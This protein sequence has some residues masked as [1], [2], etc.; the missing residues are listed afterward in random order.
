MQTIAR[1]RPELSCSAMPR[2]R[3]DGNESTNVGQNIPYKAASSAILLSMLLSGCALVGPDFLKPSAPVADSYVPVESSAGAQSKSSAKQPAKVVSAQENSIQAEEL[4][5]WWTAFKDPTLNRL[6][7]MA[8]GQNLT[9]QSAGARVLEA[10]AALGIATGNLFPQEQRLGGGVDYNRLSKEDAFAI[11]NPPSNFWRA[12][13]GAQLAWELDFWGK[14]RRNIESADAAYIASV[15]NY[16]D[17]LVTLLA[18]VASTYIGIR[19]V[20]KQ[21]DL[22]NANIVRQQ[23]ALNIASD[24]FKNG[25]TSQ[26]D[27]FQAQNVLGATKARVPQLRIQL[28]EGID[29]LRVLLGIAPQSLDG[30]IANSAGIPAAPKAVNIGIPADLLR[31]RP[32]IRN[33]EFNAAAQSAQIGVAKAD[34]FPAFSLVGNVGFISSNVGRASLSDLFTH[35]AIAYSFGPTFQWNI[36]NYGQITNNVRVQDARL[37][38][39]LVDYQNS[40]LKAQQ[41]VQ[42]GI[43][44]FV[45]SDE[46]A[47]N[48]RDSVTAATGALNLAFTQY[49][50]GLTDFTTVLTAEQNLLDAENNLAI[51]TGATSTGLV[52]IYRALGG[53]WE[54]SAG[55]EFVPPATREEMKKRTNWGDLLP[56]SA[57]PNPET[58]QPPPP[59]ID[60]TSIPAPAW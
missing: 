23:K 20:Q 3:R 55:K 58:P 33:A 51:A 32:D 18:N 15:A 27:V 7:E 14:F 41:E 36:F 50:E 48:L 53:G 6:I 49:Q 40:V 24:R 54:I 10:R 45:L 34:L 60:G 5:H 56:I 47:I 26:L 39:L 22:A 17:V 11:A 30:M 42:D 25:A 13:I 21:I 28:Q 9:L 35:H 59:Q 8:Y 19:T 43:A 37:Q 4:T 16:D 44:Q 31:R 57:G 1:Y 52:Q 12:S 38:S 2:V 46:Q 29:L